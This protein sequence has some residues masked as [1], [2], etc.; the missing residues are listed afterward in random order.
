MESLTE[1]FC[2]VDDFCQSFV[3]VWRKQMLSAGEIQRQRERSLSLSEIMTILIHF[4]QSHYRNFKAYYTEY[5]L[6]R[7][8]KE[9]PGLVS[10]NCFVE[11]IPSVL[12]AL[13]VYLCTSCLGTCTGIS[14]VDS[15]ALAVCKNPRI[16]SHKVFAGLAER[17]K[18]STGWF[19][20]FKLHLIFNDR[21]ELL[22]LMLT[23]GNVNDRKPV[24]QMVYKL[25][26]KLF[27]DK[28]YI[29]KTLRDE[30]LCTFN[31][32]LVTGIRSNMKN[33]L[34][35]LMDKILLRKRAIVETII[36][37]LKNI[38]QI[39]HSRHRSPANFLVNLICG[40]IAYCRQPKK[41]SL[42]LGTLP[43]LVA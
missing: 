10:Y 26:G 21:G 20:G 34:M 11:F 15:T 22:N 30:L 36:D 29:S 35:P 9:F 4:H 24:P 2:D 25:F 31:V 39:E 27:A 42:R 1:L 32:Q 41:P 5:V 8:R 18:T 12:L 13:C 19:F 43:A 14:F 38:S 17:G 3:S 23:P 6:E 7:L 16:H 40:L 28:G 33:A 37:Q